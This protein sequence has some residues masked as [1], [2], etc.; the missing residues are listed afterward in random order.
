[1]TWQEL[2]DNKALRH[3]AFLWEENGKTTAYLLTEI[4]EHNGIITI[5]GRSRTQSQ[6]IEERASVTTKNSITKEFSVAK[7]FSQ[8]RVEGHKIIISIPHI[9]IATF[10]SKNI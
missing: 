1:M 10:S 9:G 7:D 6:K 4:T 3:Q 5:V 8:P 2:I